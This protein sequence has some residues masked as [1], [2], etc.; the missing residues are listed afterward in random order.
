[1]PIHDISMEDVEMNTWR[2]KDTM[3]HSFGF[4]AVA[5]FVASDA[6]QQLFVFRKFNKMAARNLLEM[7]NE[8]QFL[9]QRQ[10]ELDREVELS[11]DEI[12]CKAMRNYDEFKENL[13]SHPGL[14]ER[15]KLQEQ[16]EQ[17]M[18]KYRKSS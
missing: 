9:E 16:V 4:A 18:H 6:D 7:Q 15:R 8:L 11:G 1:M 2:V 10:E 12:L 17:Q 3:T 5:D 13:D 14:Q